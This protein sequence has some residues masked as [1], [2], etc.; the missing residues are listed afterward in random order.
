MPFQPFQR[1]AKAAF[2]SEDWLL[3]GDDPSLRENFSA[4]ASI[5]EVEA[6]VFRA[7]DRL[8]ELREQ[9]IAPRIRTVTQS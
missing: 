6:F 5:E 3:V 7:Y 1:A 2:A 8:R 4:L 9:Q